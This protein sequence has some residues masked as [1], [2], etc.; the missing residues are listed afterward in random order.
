M[1]EA[2]KEHYRVNTMDSVKQH[3]M[4]A[5]PRWDA[6]NIADHYKA[7]RSVFVKSLAGG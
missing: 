3:L 1:P 2:K 7:M 6:G 5:Y 4:I